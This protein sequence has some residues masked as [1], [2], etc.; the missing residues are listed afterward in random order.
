MADAAAYTVD[1]R[2][3]GVPVVVLAERGVDESR[4]ERRARSCCR[5]PAPTLPA[6]S[7]SRSSGSSRTKKTSQALRDAADLLGGA[8]SVRTR[9][10][11][12][13]AARLT[14]APPPADGAG[15]AADLLARLADAGFIDDRRRDVDL[16]DV[17]LAS[18]RAR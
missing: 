11:D 1:G 14:D 8:N 3:T 18:A 17:S 7:G 5:R 2:L 15:P 16:D 10:L 12:E 9:A 4:R 13:L 6:S